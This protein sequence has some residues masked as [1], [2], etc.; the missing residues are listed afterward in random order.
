M[1]FVPSCGRCLPCWEGRPALCEPGGA[2]NLAGT[3]YSGAKRLRLNGGEINHHLGVSA[4][5]THAVMSHQSLVKVDPD[6]AFD[7]A[8]L[9]GCAVLTGAGAV[10]NTV[11]VPPGATVAVIGLGGIGLNSLLAAKLVAAERIVAIDTLDTKLDFA[12]QLGATDSFNARDEDCADQVRE[13]TGGGVDFA[14]EAVGLVK[15]LELAY[16]ITRRGGT[17]VTAGLAHP[18]HKL[19]IQQV[20]LVGE[21]RTLKGSYIGSCIP[22]RD[23]PRFIGLY[24]RGYLPIDRLMSDRIDFKGLNAAFDRLESGQT[25]RQILRP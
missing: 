10:L 8:A 19:A 15:A 1:V 2:A 24:K 14:F 18:E 23:V 5:A 16:Q 4:F 21:E 12:R 17:T 25:V 20:S 6:L 3:L 11:D 7:E 22:A 13:A 9:F